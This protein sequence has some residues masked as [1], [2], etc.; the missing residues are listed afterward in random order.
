M[1]E[2]TSGLHPHDIRT[3]RQALDSL[4]DRGHT[5]VVVEHDLDLVRHADWAIELGPGAGHEGGQV[6]F[7]G[8]PEELAGKD[9]PTGRVL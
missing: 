1:D 5:L 4:V 8:R 9:T 6:I 3:L 2:P 7:Q